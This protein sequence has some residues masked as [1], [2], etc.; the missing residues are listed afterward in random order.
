MLYSII[1]LITYLLSKYAYKIKSY[2]SINIIKRCIK[3]HLFT[4]GQS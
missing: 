3:I 2:Y 4:H 1:A